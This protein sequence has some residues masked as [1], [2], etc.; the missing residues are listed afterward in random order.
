MLVR[1]LAQVT[2]QTIVVAVA[3]M[4]ALP[5]FLAVSSPFIGR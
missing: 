2:T 4:V 5:F 3:L 1:K